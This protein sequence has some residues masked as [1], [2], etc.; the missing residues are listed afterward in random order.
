MRTCQAAVLT[1]Y[2]EPLELREYP[3]PIKLEPGA[4]LALE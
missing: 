3:L 1:K 4:A 2:D